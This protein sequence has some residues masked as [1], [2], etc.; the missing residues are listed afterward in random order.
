MTRHDPATGP[1]PA[2][3]AD[4]FARDCASR[5][6]FDDVTSKWASLALLALLDGR[7]RFNALRR[8]VD[9]ISEKMLSQNLRT[10]ERD[11]LLVR[12]VVD[13][14]P[15]R[16]EYEL[17]PLGREVAGHLRALADVLESTVNR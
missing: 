17:T 6:V 9:G 10:L 1:S 2:L 12:D 4:V 13:V 16:V 7:T 3:V 14:I 8:R 5:A 11:G 15:A